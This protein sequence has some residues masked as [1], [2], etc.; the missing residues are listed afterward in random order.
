MRY[1][2][3]ILIGTLAFALTAVVLLLAYNVANPPA[4]STISA[5]ANPTHAALLLT[6]HA[7]GSKAQQTPAEKPTSVPAETTPLE[8]GPVQ[9]PP[10]PSNASA[11][12]R[13]GMMLRTD[14]DYT[15]AAESFRAAINEK[16]DPSIVREAQFRLGEMLYL[17]GDN[18]NAAAELNQLIAARDGDDFAMRAHYFLADILRQ[19]KN[20]DQAL[21]HLRE[22]RALTRSLQGEA[23]AQMGDIM[24]EAGN[25]TGALAQ[26]ASA[27]K[28]SALT[29]EQRISY[30]EELATAQMQ[31][32][33]P[34]SAAESLSK[35]YELTPDNGSAADVENRWA[36]AL[37]AAGDRAGAVA[38]W[39]HAVTTFPEEAGAYQSLIALLDANEP[40]DD[41][42]RGLIDIYNDALDPAIQAF[43]RYIAANPDNSAN[44]MYFLARAYDKGNQT[45]LAIKTYD[46]LLQKYPEAE[47]A[48]DALYYKG[49]AYEALKDTTHAVATYNE[50][51]R[52]FPANERADDAL[53][54][55]AHALE[56][57]GRNDQARAEYQLLA[58]KFPKSSFASAALFN[59]GLDYYMANDKAKAE[60]QWKSLAAEYPNTADADHA[61]FW[62][63]KLARAR[64][65]AAANALLAESA[66]PP[67]SYYGW[68]AL[69]LLE[70]QKARPS[71]NVADYAM[72]ADP[73]L[74]AEAEKWLVGWT[75][76]PVSAEIPA[77]LA[78]DPHFRRGAE[79]AA[80]DEDSLAR[81]EFQRVLS[82][83]RRDARIL[84]PF[85]RYLSE[86]NYFDISIEAAQ[87][88]QTLSGASDEEL[89][90]YIRQLIYPT[91]YA[92]LVVPY[93]QRYGFDPALFF[94]LM[95]QESRYNP[96]AK[97]YV[98]AAGL[99]QVM[100]ATGAGIARELGIR[101][102]RPSDLQR[103]F[104]S[105]RFGT[106]Y[107]GQLLKSFDGNVLYS[108]G[109][110][111]AGPGNA[112]KWIRPDVD[113]AVEIIH[114]PETYNYVRTVY[115]QYSQYLE[116]YRGR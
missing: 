18:E 70:P 78:N 103:P 101:N 112:K 91:Y 12:F 107:F 14:G 38:H 52:R 4:T 50:L 95:R 87:Q 116:I 42:Q 13:Q 20:Y 28:D 49:K 71:Y 1:A 34:A 39:R 113:E 24:M 93:A 96:T 30:L 22:F 65:D 47:H 32:G 74:A 105:I 15:R 41:Y 114:L 73:K 62:L 110:Y 51:A 27:L 102:F 25:V 106:Y 46:S 44:A 81:V 3:P 100:P 86:N 33:D 90:V 88:I 99:T 111:N 108:L 9:L 94:A 77:A 83:F 115:S 11:T 67:R 72:N 35:A 61:L 29:V 31:N 45:S 54:Y 7:A 82:T 8:V 6:P 57:D 2:R 26:Y 58:T 36:T 104:N 43:K 48:A 37:L 19:Q 98:G 21:E 10:P 76:G 79:L 68:R 109:G 75:D 64:G 53:W 69:D 40:V 84:Y 89:P 56:L 60:A 16:L 97:S 55:A 23:D 5:S 92:D 80:V 85:A 63:G 66:K 59:I 17:A